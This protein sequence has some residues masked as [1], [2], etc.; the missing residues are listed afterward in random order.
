[1]RGRDHTLLA[2]GIF[3]IL[4]LMAASAASAQVVIKVNDDAFFKLGL[5]LQTQADA[6]E[7]PATGAYAQNVFVRR[8]R[9][10]LGGQISKQLSFFVETDSPNLGKS[11]ATGTKNSQ[12]SMYLQDA[13]VEWK[14]SDQFLLNAGLM[15]PSPSRNGVQSAA[16]LLPIDYGPYTFANSAPTQSSV[17]RDTGIQARGYLANKRLEYRAG[18]YQ[19]MRDKQNRELRFT[20]RLQYNFLETES[21][22][23]YT[24]TNLGK[25]KVLAIGAGIDR[26]HEYEGYAL[27]VFFDHPVGNGALT[28]Q[29]DHIRYDGGSFLQSL[30][31]QHTTQ[32]EAGYL[33]GRSRVMPVVQMSRRTFSNGHSFDENRYGAGVNYYISGHNANIKAFYTRID[34]DGT[35]AA[36]Q[37]TVQIQFFYY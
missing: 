27:D 36:N 5:L 26:Q 29:L 18:I 13:Y 33:I 37:L 6:L 23:F 12:P 14:V 9:L 35:A 19:G 25:K 8:V 11:V 34:N 3:L 7:D 28:T 17:G 22:F 31:N 24:G 15:L 16:S 10:L 21:G 30:P 1:M 32:F 4:T 2:T 20:G